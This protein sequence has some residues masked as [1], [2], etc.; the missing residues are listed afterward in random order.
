MDDD[1][2]T[3][4]GLAAIFE[5]VSITNKNLDNQEF[6]TASRDILLELSKLFG[7]SISPSVEV[8]ALFLRAD[9]HGV[10][11]LIKEREEARKNKDFKKSDQLRKEIEDLG[12]ILEDTKD[13]PTF[14]KKL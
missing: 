4:Q 8:E 5:L 2:N 1:F 14:R 9:L 13:G 11:V 10:Q 12:F 6:V 3:P 7:L